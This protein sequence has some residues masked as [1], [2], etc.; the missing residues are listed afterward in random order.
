M[1]TGGYLEM[2][3]NLR[4][5]LVLFG[6]LNFVVVFLVQ[7]QGPTND[8]NSQGFTKYPTAIPQEETIFSPV[9]TELSFEEIIQ[10]ISTSPVGESYE[11]LEEEPNFP[12]WFLDYISLHNK[13]T[14]PQD[15]IVPKKFVIPDMHPLAG[16]C[17]RIGNLVSSLLFAILTNRALVFNWDQTSGDHEY[18]EGGVREKVGQ[19]D[20]T[21]LF[22]ALPFEH[23]WSVVKQRLNVN[24][25]SSKM[26]NW[27]AERSPSP[28]RNLSDQFPE[29]IVNTV[30]YD[31]WG[32]LLY[33]NELYQEFIKTEIGLPLFKNLAAPFLRPSGTILEM[34]R[35]HDTT[36]DVG[37]QVRFNFGR[38]TATPAQFVN[39]GNRIVNRKDLPL[40]G[41]WLLATDEEKVIGDMKTL[42]GDQIVALK[43]P[44]LPIPCRDGK[45]CNQQAIYEMFAL[46]KC[47]EV[48]TSF[49]ST[50][51][52]CGAGFSGT[53][54]YVITPDNRCYKTESSDP[55]NAG[56]LDN[57]PT[58]T[59]YFQTCPPRTGFWSLWVAKQSVTWVRLTW[60]AP[61]KG[62]HIYIME[63]QFG[64]NFQIIKT[65]ES[66]KD[67]IEQD[68]EGLQPEKTYSFRVQIQDFSRVSLVATARTSP[69]LHRMVDFPDPNI[70][71]LRQ[72]QGREKACLYYIFGNAD[73][74]HLVKLRESIKRLD[75]F[76]N[77]RFGYP[78]FILH[79]DDLTKE[80]RQKI[81][82]WTRS[83]IDF[84]NV[85]KQLNVPDFMKNQSYPEMWKLP[86][87][88]KSIFPVGYRSAARF[89]SGPIYQLEFLKDFEYFWKIDDD[90]FLINHVKEDP[91]VVMK[92]GN[93]ILGYLN[94]YEDTPKVTEGLDNAFRN[95][96]REKN[97][98]MTW[99]DRVFPNGK[100]NNWNYYGFSIMGK[101][102]FFRSQEFY[103]IFEYLDPLGGWYKHRWDEQKVISFAM[104]AFRTSSDVQN[105]A[106]I[107]PI[108]HQGF[109]S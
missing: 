31:W 49:T 8:K 90:A 25:G 53:V 35:E 4:I 97:I 83:T 17:N 43:D 81:L 29:V 94:E 104:A 20:F 34:L 30:R 86:G 52:K 109:T 9:S 107:I 48:V 91:F 39:C 59:S 73:Q 60:V 14:D 36:C 40:E 66:D 106:S 44:D 10:E 61:V 75:T 3:T 63:N 93:K 77:D 78:V 64:D 11:N 82:S 33:E 101:L 96:I 62:K 38:A 67:V 87:S 45:K 99:S 74:D 58:F 105:V 6:L 84:V 23:R 16:N 88:E 27:E 12:R 50:F 24:E 42:L 13:I 37:L 85:Q 19:A 28:C 89:A 100:Y 95:F 15:N 54:P 47:K 70:P 22:K 41:K 98:Q 32:N 72:N 102:S 5:F 108:Y 79:G 55:L 103:S 76:F 7:R 69:D 57:N 92:R 71:I 68:I 1:H 80:I 46:A 56:D 21:D 65:I 26:F 51:G 2:R 18:K